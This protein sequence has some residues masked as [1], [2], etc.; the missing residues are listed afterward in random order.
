MK[1]ALVKF[2][3]AATKTTDSK[4]EEGRMALIG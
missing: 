4:K 1:L 3:F 2:L